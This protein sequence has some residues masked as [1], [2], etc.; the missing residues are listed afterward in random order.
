MA[1]GGVS[2]FLVAMAFLVATDL[3]K[4]MAIEKV[5]ALGEAMA[6]AN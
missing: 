6:M 1:L 2:A 5:V 4:G 3:G